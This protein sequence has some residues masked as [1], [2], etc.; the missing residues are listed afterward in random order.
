MIVSGP[1]TDTKV[2]DIVSMQVPNA[3]PYGVELVPD[4]DG[5]GAVIKAWGKMPDGKY[6]PIQRHKV[7]LLCAFVCRVCMWHAEG[8]NA[9]VRTSNPSPSLLCTASSKSSPAP[10]LTHHTPRPREYTSATHW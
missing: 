9:H 6:G 8:A 1:D 4:R 3:G 10:V 5:Q 2:G 7:Q